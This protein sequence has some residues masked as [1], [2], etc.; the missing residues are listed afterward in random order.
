MDRLTT[1]EHGDSGWAGG[2][3]CEKVPLLCEAYEFSCGACPLGRVLEKLCKYEDTG[4]EP[5]AVQVLAN[6][7]ILNSRNRHG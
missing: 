7:Y 3:Y 2:D 4:L 1:R 6:E 5:E